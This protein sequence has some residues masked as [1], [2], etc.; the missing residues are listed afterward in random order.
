MTIETIKGQSEQE[1]RAKLTELN[2]EN[3]KARFTTEVMNPRKGSDIRKRRREIARIK[4]VLHGRAAQARREAE[5]KKLTL[6]LQAFGQP[7]QGSVEHKRLRSKIAARLEAAQRSLRELAAVTTEATA[8]AAK[9]KTEPKAEKPK[10]EVKAEA[11]PAKAEK[12]EKAEKKE[13]KPA[14]AEKADKAEKKEAK[15]AKAEKAE[16]ADK[17]EAKGAKK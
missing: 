5:V 1:L 6:A 17:K 13:A 12:A 14:K 10:A 11:K 7:H 3:F 8:K 4:T 2:A 9:P 16:K 15:P